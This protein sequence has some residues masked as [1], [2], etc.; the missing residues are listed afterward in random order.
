MVSADVIVPA[1]D[2][3]DVSVEAIALALVKYR[4]DPS[5]RLE[6][7]STI[8]YPANVVGVDVILDQAT[9]VMNAL[10]MDAPFQVPE[11]IVPT[12]VIDAC[13]T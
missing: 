1:P 9:D 6:V 5:G 7:V 10:V 3:Y 4:F 13:P 12:V 11:V 2:V 8:P